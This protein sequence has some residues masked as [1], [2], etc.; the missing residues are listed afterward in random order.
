LNTNFL[1]EQSHID[2]DS[3]ILLVKRAKEK[4]GVNVDGKLSELGCH[5]TVVHWAPLSMEFS[6]QKYWIV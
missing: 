3:D 1:E 2:E 5:K 6:I 4:S